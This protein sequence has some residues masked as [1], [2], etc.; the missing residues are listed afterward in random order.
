MR[1]QRRTPFS[2]SNAHMRGG[3]QWGP[4]EGQ[5]RDSTCMV[6]A[7]SGRASGCGPKS[8]PLAQEQRQVRLKERLICEGAPFLNLGQGVCVFWGPSQ[9][10]SLLHYVLGNLV[11]G[12]NR[13]DELRSSLVGVEGEGAVGLFKPQSSSDLEFLR[14]QKIDLGKVNYYPPSCSQQL[15][16]QYEKW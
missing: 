3:V 10:P 14:N 13:G 7:M 6:Q 15:S 11:K 5:G 1:R 16:Y 12:G 2:P 8:K 9:G 4:E